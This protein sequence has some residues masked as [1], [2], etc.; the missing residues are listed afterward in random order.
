MFPKSVRKIAARAVF[1]IGLFLM[2]LGIAFLLGTLTGVSRLSVFASFLV[3]IIGAL[4]AVVAIK[5]NKRSI[6]LFFAAFFILIGFFLFLSVMGIVPVSFSRGWPFLSVFAGLAL[7]PAGWHH[8]GA[9][10]GRY[11]V[12]SLAFIVLG[13]VLIIF[14]FDIVPFSFK[15]FIL[16]WW[17]LVVAL[18]GL[19]L[20]LLSLGT[21]SRA[22]DQKP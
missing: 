5:L 15:Q 18:A 20:V 8:Y 1:I 19:I 16:N 9:I 7:F 21:K 3:V 11:V 4:F 13:C 14:S 2:L 22:E 12:P 17:P 10:K 6:Y